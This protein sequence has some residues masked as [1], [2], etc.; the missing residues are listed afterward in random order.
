MFKVQELK[1]PGCPGKR[2]SRKLPK[3][4]ELVLASLLAALPAGVQAQADP[5]AAAA[6]AAAAVKAGTGFKELVQSMGGGIRYYSDNTSKISSPDPDVKAVGQGVNMAGPSLDITYT[7]RKERPDRR[8]LYLEWESNNSWAAGTSRSSQSASDDSGVFFAGGSTENM[9]V[10]LTTTADSTGAQAVADVTL[11]DS[12]GGTTSIYSSASSPS[13]SGA[14]IS[15]WA[16]SPSADGGVYVALT[17]DGDAP[18]AAAYGL[19]YDDLGFG[20]FGV[21]DVGETTVNSTYGESLFLTRQRLSLSTVYELEND[22]TFTPRAGPTVMFLDR[23]SK[24]STIL[25]IDKGNPAVGELPDIGIFEAIKVQSGYLGAS[26]GASFSRRLNDTWVLDLGADI[27]VTRYRA[28]YNGRRSV[29]IDGVSSSGEL[30]ARDS[31]SGTAYVGQVKIS[32]ARQFNGNA[33]LRL[34]LAADYISKVPYVLTSATGISSDGS[35][36]IYDGSSTSP[37]AGRLKM[38]SVWSPSIQISYVISF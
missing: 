26:V 17:T 28:W 12:A 18:Q 14:A 29:L 4:A 21:G 36:L 34:S 10:N 24:R 20:F 33:L 23:R 30:F 9:T 38:A 3:G 8:P 37:L 35:S 27:G 2:K 6:A 19:L 31:R 15:Q 22:W 5:G 13:G 16:F 32:L 7:Y 11:T 25:D 1:A